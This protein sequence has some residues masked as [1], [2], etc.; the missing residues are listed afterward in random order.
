LKFFLLLAILAPP[1]IFIN[2]PGTV[3]K[4]CSVELVD[5]MHHLRPC[6][7]CIFSDPQPTPAKSQFLEAG[8]RNLV[9]GVCFIFCFCGTEG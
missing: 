8:A 1:A 5:W 6:E 9:V 7:K 4:T 3:Y 2:K